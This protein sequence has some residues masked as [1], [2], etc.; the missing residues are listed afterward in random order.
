MP[1]S[2]GYHLTVLDYMHMIILLLTDNI[3]P[4]SYK[5]GIE[6]LISS[7]TGNLPSHDISSVV[8]SHATHLYQV[9]LMAHDEFCRVLYSS[10]LTNVAYLENAAKLLNKL[11]SIY[12]D[13]SQLNGSVTS[14]FEKQI[15]A[16]SQKYLP[17]FMCVSFKA[18]KDGYSDSL[19]GYSNI[20]YMHA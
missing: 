1:A 11:N 20:M 2:F 8:V 14:S 4:E 6:E 15:V 9:M 3:I 13:N 18:M 5:A 7:S 17:E 19:S 12:E 10:K 16:V